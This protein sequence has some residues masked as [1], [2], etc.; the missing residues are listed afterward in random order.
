MVIPA[1]KSGAESDVLMDI[2]DFL[3]PLLDDRM[4]QLPKGSVMLYTG[5]L[6]DARKLKGWAVMDGYNGTDYYLGDYVRLASVAGCCGGSSTHDHDTDEPGHTHDATGASDEAAANWSGTECACLCEACADICSM[7][8]APNT[9]CCFCAGCHPE[10]VHCDYSLYDHCHEVCWTQCAHT[11]Q[12]LGHLH[13]I[14]AHDHWVDI[15]TTAGDADITVCAASSE[16]PYETF[17]PLLK[18]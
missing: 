8:A 9:C 6:K 3:M 13:T 4:E 10:D 2:Q 5:T 16:P 17:I 18:L 14:P 12:T 15:T 1:E 11:H 7:W